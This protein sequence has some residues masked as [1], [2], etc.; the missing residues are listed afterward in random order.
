MDHFSRHVIWDKTISSITRTILCDA[1]TSGGL[2]FTVPTK[3]KDGIMADLKKSGIIHASHIGN[4]HG[5]G[6]GKIYVKK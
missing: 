2:L 5:R 3:E 6:A 4:C 1:Q